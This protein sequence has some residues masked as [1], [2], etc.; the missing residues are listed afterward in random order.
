MFEKDKHRKNPSGDP[1]AASGGAPKMDQHALSGLSFY[2]YS[3]EIAAAFG[4]TEAA[5]TTI[6]QGNQTLLVW[7]LNKEQTYSFVFPDNGSAQKAHRMIVHR[8]S[9]SL[10][11]LKAKFVTSTSPQT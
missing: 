9:T 6:P 7:G 3:K 10:S 5:S 8:F 4:G 11:G 1:V 2:A